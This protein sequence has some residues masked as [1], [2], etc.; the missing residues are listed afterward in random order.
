MRSAPAPDA[1][2]PAVDARSVSSKKKM[3]N[4]AETTQLYT[5][6]LYITIIYFY[7]YTNRFDINVVELKMDSKIWI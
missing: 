3:Y 6:D 5:L 2:A 7:K 1:P 4:A